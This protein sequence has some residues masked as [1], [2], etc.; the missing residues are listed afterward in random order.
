MRRT[1]LSWVLVVAAGAAAGAGSGCTSSNPAPKPSGTRAEMIAPHT[2]ANCH[3]DHFNQWSQ[4]MHAQAA[5]DPVFLAMNARGQR[6]TKG[7]LGTFCVQC[8]APMAVRDGKTK[9]GLNL[10]SLDPTYKGVT[11]YFCHSID[12]TDADAGKNNASVHIADDLVMRG[13]FSDPADNP[14]HASM[15]SKFQDRY[16]PESAVMCGACHDIESPAGGAIERTFA[17][18]S[19]TPFATKNAETCSGDGCH[20][21]ASAKPRLIATGGTKLRPFH[22]HD[23]PA[24]DVPLQANPPAAQV[25]AVEDALNNNSVQGALCVTDQGGIRVILDTTKIGHDWPSGA[26]QD[27]RAWTEVEAFGADGSMIYSSGVVP[28]GGSVTDLAATDQ[29]LWL[30]RDC[31]FDSQGKETHNFWEA[32]TVSGY[33]LPALLTFDPTAAAFYNNH[34]GQT[35]PR[36]NSASPTLRYPARV[37]LRVRIQ[38]VGLDVLNDLV[39]SGDLDAGPDGALLAAMPTFDVSLQGPVG[40]GYPPPAGLE[41]T[42]GASDLVTTEDALGLQGQMKCKVSPTDFNPVVH[43]SGK[44]VPTCR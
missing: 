40:P 7:K 12:S 3:E 13:D 26:A 20:M 10:A 32:K 4:S 1:W 41:W 24:V 19:A 9:D 38:P 35:F 42:P 27:R 23:F 14:V 6:E 5:D 15:Y 28:P 37:T 2:C 17:E 11:C 30:L 29:D 44:S 21:T 16:Q 18:W 34:I 25:Q 8:H 31:M 33:E 43:V 39:A 36:A 22:E